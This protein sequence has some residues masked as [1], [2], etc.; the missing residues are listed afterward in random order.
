VT[1]LPLTEDSPKPKLYRTKSPVRFTLFNNNLEAEKQFS[2]LL[3]PVQKIPLL[4]FYIN[5]VTDFLEV[6]PEKFIVIERSY[7]AGRG[8]FSHNVLLFYADASNAT[9]TL[10]I[11]RL[12]RKIK[13]QVIPANKELIFNFNDVRKLLKE[14]QIDNLEGICFGPKL[15]NGH[16]T[17]VLVSDNNFN[18]FTQQLNQIIWLEIIPN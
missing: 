12:K 7:A 13:K 16:Q 5:G 3:E 8:K 17:L 4:P 2:Y 15:K 10:E 14:K 6:S 1:E 9:N 11:E 18:S